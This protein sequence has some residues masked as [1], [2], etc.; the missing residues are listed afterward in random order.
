MNLDISR[1]LHWIRACLGAEPAHN[2]LVEAVFYEVEVLDYVPSRLL[3]QPDEVFRV[4]NT[5]QVVRFAP[6][7]T[8]LN[9]SLV[10][11]VYLKLA[12]KLF[13]VKCFL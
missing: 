6:V 13:Q 2:H 10:H 1:G 9:N 4:L 5:D 11:L 8:S 12:K 7:F 3:Y